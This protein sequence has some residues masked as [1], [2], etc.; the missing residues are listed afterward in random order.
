MSEKYGSGTAGASARNIIEVCKEPC[1][2]CKGKADKTLDFDVR[3][4]ISQLAV[5]VGCV[6]AVKQKVI[7]DLVKIGQIDTEG[8]FG[9]N[10]HG[11]A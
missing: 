10:G 2:G 11:R 7:V 3:G 9:F 6:D 4:D 1:V 5:C 8:T